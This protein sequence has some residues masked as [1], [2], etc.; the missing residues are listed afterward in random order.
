MHSTKSPNWLTTAWGAL[1]TYEKTGQPIAK[2][3]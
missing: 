2:V 1:V 3:S